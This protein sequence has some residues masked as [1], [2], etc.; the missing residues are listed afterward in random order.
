MYLRRHEDNV[1]INELHM[2]AKPGLNRARS[3][4]LTD[5]P[6]LPLDLAPSAWHLSPTGE[7]WRLTVIIGHSNFLIRSVLC[8]KNASK[9]TFAAWDVAQ[10]PINGC[11]NWL[12]KWQICGGR[13]ECS[14][15]TMKGEGPGT[16]VKLHL[17]YK[18]AAFLSPS[19]VYRC[20]SVG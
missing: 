9:S 16:S 11:T 17:I 2:T 15:G 3:C 10:D 8:A 13:K 12:S 6:P 4:H 14:R 19:D 7:I 1:S 18:C 5:Q 20:H